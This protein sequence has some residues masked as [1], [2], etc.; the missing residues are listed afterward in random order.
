MQV[1]F[2]VS[3]KKEDARENHLKVM[4]T[5]NGGNITVFVEPE[6]T[7]GHYNLTI[8]YPFEWTAGVS[9]TRVRP[10]PASVYK[11]K[12]D[13]TNSD[14]RKYVCFSGVNT[15]SFRETVTAIVTITSME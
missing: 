7:D 5:Y 15:T 11:E 6:K 13:G 4:G 8:S 12:A 1:V 14:G 9:L 10:C 3:I 2:R